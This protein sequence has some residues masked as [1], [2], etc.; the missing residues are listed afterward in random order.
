[1]HPNF[2]ATQFV[3]EKFAEQFLSE[4]SVCVIKEIQPILQRL[5]IRVFILKRRPPAV[6]AGAA[7]EDLII[8]EEVPGH[9]PYEET[10]FFL[11]NVKE[12]KN[13]DAI[14]LTGDHLPPLA[15]QVFIFMARRTDLSIQV[16]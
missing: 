16:V 12:L 7:T 10:R 6:F 8:F 14:V 13:V 9:R 4:E 1:M 5:I 11:N 3:F 15:D 2:A